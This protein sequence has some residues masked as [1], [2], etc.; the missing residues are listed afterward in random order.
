MTL[1]TMCLIFAFVSP[2]PGNEGGV[3]VTAGVA[4]FAQPHS[5]E[6]AQTSASAKRRDTCIPNASADW[7]E[8]LL[9]FTRIG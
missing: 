6:I 4:F 3:V 1:Q 8:R 9:Q 5:S 7:R 2:T